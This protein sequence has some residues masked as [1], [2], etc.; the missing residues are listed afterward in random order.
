MESGSSAKAKGSTLKLS[1]FGVPGKVLAGWGQK[2]ELEGRASKWGGGQS[3]AVRGAVEESPV[4][5][6]ESDLSTS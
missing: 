3:R 5:W 2:R 1:D 6:G 4:S